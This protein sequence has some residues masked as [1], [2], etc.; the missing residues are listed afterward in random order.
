MARS[1]HNVAGNIQWLTDIYNSRDHHSG[2]SN[3]ITTRHENSFRDVINFDGFDGGSYEL[4]RL[5]PNRWSHADMV[6]SASYV[7][8]RICNPITLQLLAIE[9]VG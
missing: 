3:A 2:A 6:G 7:G 5:S 1:I 4:N 8:N 9:S